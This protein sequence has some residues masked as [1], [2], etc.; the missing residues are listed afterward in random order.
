MKGLNKIQ[1]IT[2]RPVVAR[3]AAAME[4]KLRDKDT[5]K[6]AEGWKNSSVPY[7]MERLDEEVKEL[8]KALHEWPM[9]MKTNTIMNEAADVANFTMMVADLTGSLP[10]R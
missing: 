10:R 8:K 1:A 2:L 6:G 3:F 7:L 9:G 5:E 4:M